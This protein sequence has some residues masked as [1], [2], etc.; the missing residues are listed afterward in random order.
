MSALLKRV[1]FNCDADDK[2]GS[3]LNLRVDYDVAIAGPEWSARP[4]RSPL[5]LPI[6]YAARE[7]TPS[8]LGVFANFSWRGLPPKRLEVQ[9]IPANPRRGG[10]GQTSQL[11]RQ[12]AES[13]AALSPQLAAYYAYLADLVQDTAP[14]LGTI[15]PTPVTIGPDGD[16]GAVFLRLNGSTLRGAPVG[17]HEIAWRWQYRTADAPQ[18]HDFDTSYH[19][20]HTTLD[21]P[22]APWLQRP[23]E[24]WN[25]ALPWSK[26]LDYACTWAAGARTKGEIATL[27]C[28][29]VHQM[30]GGNIE[31]GCPIGAREMYANTPLGIF[32]LTALIER[33][34]G[35]MGNGQYVN[36]T[37][38]ACA[39]STFANLLGAELWQGRMGEY[40]PAFMLRDSQMI[41]HSSWSSPCNLGLGFMFHEVGWNGNCEEYDEVYDASVVVDGNLSPFPHP[42]YPILPAGL[43]FGTAWQTFYRRMLAAPQSLYVCH[44]LPEERRR[45]ALI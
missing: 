17:I 23:A 28:A 19:R 22:V 41:G 34:E 27:V 12:L 6:V 36:C 11:Y 33:I 10:T 18:W 39:V 2:R 20:I 31:Y 15:A 8:R 40:V 38:C 42:P 5:E 45:R 35:G 1:L 3:G 32:D 29:A 43:Q 4:G 9:A 7:I 21:L 30:G 25:S 44:P 13:W 26:A 37:D 16:S 14:L 24:V